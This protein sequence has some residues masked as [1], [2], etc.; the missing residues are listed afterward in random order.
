IGGRLVARLAAH[1]VGPICAPVRGYRHCVELA[2][3]GVE[4]PRLDLLDAAAVRQAVRGSV[5]VFHLAYGRDGDRA[6]RVTTEGTRN[7][8]EAAIAEGCESVVVL[9]TMYVFGRPE[10]DALVD[11]TWPY[12]PVGGEYGASKAAMERWCLARARSSGR[13]RVVVLNPSCV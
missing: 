11:E 10:T 7:V 2:R 5:R 12:A 9:S 1:D 4:I 8:V 6:A 3:F 13:T